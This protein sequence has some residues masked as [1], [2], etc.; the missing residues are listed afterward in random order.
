M[1]KV[2]LRSNKIDAGSMAKSPTLIAAFP[3]T[4]IEKVLVLS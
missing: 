1:V 4:M 3:T 2:V